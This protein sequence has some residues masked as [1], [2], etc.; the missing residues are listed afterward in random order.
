VSLKAL[1]DQIAAEF[2][3]GVVSSFTVTWI[4]AGVFA[5][6]GLIGA[7]FTRMPSNKSAAL[8]QDGEV[9]EVADVPAVS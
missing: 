7:F 2:K 6:L 1:G 3:N 5:L 8:A 9:L 4:F